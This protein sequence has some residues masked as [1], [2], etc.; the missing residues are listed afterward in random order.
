MT[1][2]GS[3]QGTV[4]DF[5]STSHNIVKN[6]DLDGN[7]QKPA[8]GPQTAG[9]CTGVNIGGSYNTLQNCNVH[10]IADDGVS[11]GGDFHLLSGNHIHDLHGCGTDS[12]PQCGPCY[13]G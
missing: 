4:V 7:F 12:T 11:I 6:C 1:V 2:L 9:A 3:F 8:T 5:R 10:N 13:N